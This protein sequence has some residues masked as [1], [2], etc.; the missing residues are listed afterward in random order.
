M[1]PELTFIM[2]RVAPAAFI[3]AFGAC[4]GSLINVLV[5]RLPR[6]LSV[7]TPPS[8][9]PS[10][11]TRLTWRENIPIFGWLLLRGKCRFCKSD[12]SPEY[13][14]VEAFTA[15]LVT[16]FFVLYWQVD[17]S[18]TWLGVHWG[19]IRPD[20]M[21]P[22]APSVVWPTFA[23]LV[24]LLGSLVAM[25]LVDAKTFTIPLVLP[26]F[27]AALG[28]VTHTAHAAWV[29]WRLGKLPA[30]VP[31]WDWV[32]PT[33]GTG[34]APG[35]AGSG[36]WWVGACT[37]AV[38]GLAVSMA[39]VKAGLI[40]RSYADYD[41]WEAKELAARG[42]TREQLEGEDGAPT[43]WRLVLL[44]TV[45]GIGVTVV[46][47][48]AGYSV[49]GAFGQPGWAGTLAGAAAG[50]ILAGLLARLLVPTPAGEARSD[51]GAVATD[52]A[53][54]GEGVPTAGA[55]VGTPV[56][57]DV[58]SAPDMW[59]AYPHARR[60]AIKEFVFLSPPVCLGAL[61]GWGAL[62]TLGDRGLPLWLAAL[63]G[64]LMGYLIGGLVVWTVRIGGTLGFDKDAMGL[65]D[66]HMVAGIGACLGWIDATL[67][68][69]GAAFVGLLWWVAQRAWPGG[70]GRRAMPYGPFI[71]GAT[72]L[73]L[74]TKPLIEMG[75]NRLLPPGPGQMPIH[76]P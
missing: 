39:L 1:S 32:I 7:V 63:T 55:A 43:D 57:T 62:H 29:Q 54:A 3:F 64:A 49:A 59:I 19:A 72:V 73:V 33:P 17:P 74:L 15:V 12:I 51:R 47:A 38:V 67:A 6:G 60:E 66:V 30:H 44:R 26:W 9:C 31:G 46:L 76:L 4:M 11:G 48:S 70:S 61:A 23:M 68:F 24:L 58:P 56:A 50:P 28:I 8:A 75:L 40:H 45:L 21:T 65:G 20:W 71:A 36:W 35:S 52:G 42:V 41:E 22:Y 5:Y 27:L 18:A 10:C 37:G 25:T 16:A 2:S 53:P 34:R 13:P 14:L 69:F